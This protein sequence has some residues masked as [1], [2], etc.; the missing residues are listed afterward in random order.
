MKPV[1]VGMGEV[2]WD[3]FPGGRV[4]GGAPA[5]FAYHANQMG[6]TG[7]IASSVGNDESGRGILSGLHDMGLD[8]RF[9][10]IHEKCPTGTV[11]V[12]VDS[13]GKPSYT[14]NEYV[15]WD[16]IPFAMDVAALARTTDAVCV[17]SLAQRSEIS[18]RTI[19]RFLDATRLECWRVFDINLRQKFYAR[20]TIEATLSKTRLLKLNDEEWPILAE[21]FGVTTVVPGGLKKLMRRF[22]IEIVA[23]TRG[24][25]GSLICSHSL[26]HA[27]QA[28]PVQVVDTVGAG[29]SFTAALVMGILRG[30]PLPLAHE[31]ASRVAA[32]VCTQ[33]G[34]TPK[35]PTELVL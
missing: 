5:N 29:D 23:L 28:P 1:V 33:R 7:I 15:A 16:S 34:A 13:G 20:E 35:I 30:H 24:A 22:G 19:Q 31:H 17:G 10:H 6:A 21:M 32:Y 2:L 3:V 4:L 11:T 26:T 18:C 14:I 25:E 27:V 12:S 9:I 8:S